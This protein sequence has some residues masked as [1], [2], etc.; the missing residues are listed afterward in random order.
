MTD[1]TDLIARVEAL[2]ATSNA[3]DVEVEVA[4]FE[5]TGVSVACRPNDAGT[6]VIYTYCDGSRKTYLADDWTLT[7]EQR[8][9]TIRLLKE[10]LSNV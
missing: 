8:A 7:D 1:L 10:R 9:E 4:L 3:I 6:K 5:P 2:T